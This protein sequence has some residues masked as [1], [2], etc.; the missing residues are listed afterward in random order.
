MR[1]SEMNRLPRKSENGFTLLEVMIAMAVTL[2]ILAGA[3]QLFTQAIQT[4][5]L[6]L[7]RAEVQTEVRAA[8]NLIERDLSRA[9]TGVPLGGIAIPSTASGGA[10]PNFACDSSQCYLTV[11]VPFTQGTLYSVTPAS[12]IG[13]TIT[14]PSDAIKITY[15]DP[16]LDWS[17]FPP[18]S[19]TA[20]SL[21]MPPLTT[22]AVSDAA[23]GITPGD[24]ILLQ[25]SIG[26]AVG[27]ATSVPAP[28]I[29]FG[30]DPL[31]I[32]QSA[33]PAGNIAAIATPGTTTFPATKV[34]RLVMITYFLQTVVTPDGL[35][36]RLMRQEG[37]HPPVPVA[38]HIEDFQITYDIVD[39]TT[40]A[41]TANL[42]NAV[43]GTPPLPEP[44]QIRKINISI[45]GRSFRPGIKKQVQRVNLSTSI[46]P[47][48]L[49]FK[50]RYQ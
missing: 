3:V 34:S 40:S 27:V 22:P 10:N 20:T 35:D 15:V 36:A 28:T 17:A 39:P 1:K 47:R 45:T 19:I 29:N 41:V 32:N 44:N 50:D 12:A 8:L 4:S 13:P 18:T 14:E 46:G 42:P 11:N 25:N 23:V 2:I 6:T 21:T 24:V 43:G 38:E 7:Q 5:D 37:T 31:N 30:V 48:N 16:S 9:G 49:S 26:A 33:A